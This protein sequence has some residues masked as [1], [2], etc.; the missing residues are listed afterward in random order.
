MLEVTIKLAIVFRLTVDRLDK[1]TKF[2]IFEAHA[3]RQNLLLSPSTTRIEAVNSTSPALFMTAE[4]VLD[5][6]GAIL[7][8]PHLTNLTALGNSVASS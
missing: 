6:G 2:V 7:Y 8:N 4:L 5:L 1:G 3:L